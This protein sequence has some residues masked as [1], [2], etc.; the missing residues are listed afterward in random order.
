MP[1]PD[2]ST[3]VSLARYPELMDQPCTLADLRA[4][5]RDISRVTALLGGYRPTMHWLSHVYGVMP[6][7]PRPIHIVDV[8]CGYGDFLRRI[9]RWAQDRNLPVT[10]TGIDLNPDTVQVARAA[11]IPGTVTYLAGNAFDF[12]PPQ[13]IDIVISSLVMHHLENREIVDLL[14]WMESNAK[15][16]WFINDLHRQKLS[17]RLFRMLAAVMPWHRFV[18]HD[19]PVSILRSFRT[20][21]WTALLKAAAIPAGGYAI[22][23][24]RPGRL[25]VARLKTPNSPL[26]THNS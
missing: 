24:Y 20:A 1:A 18:K 11:T 7:Q 14:D 9:H 10:L 8:G 22:R 25:C 15:L 2:L 26:K 4:C 6:V 5:L 17:W 21:D 16:G 23:H 13:G 19:G 3:R 12:H